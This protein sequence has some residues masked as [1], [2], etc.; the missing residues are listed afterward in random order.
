KKIDFATAARKH[1]QD[2]TAAMD[3]DL[4][5]LPRK[6]SFMDEAFTKAAFALKPGELSDIVETEFGLH[7]ILVAARKPGQPS[8]YDKCKDEVREAFADD[9]RAELV[10]KLRKEAQIKVT[11]P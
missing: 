2:P 8:Q 5:F 3:G 10:A 4:G 9:Y 7:L 6:G 11:L 1:S